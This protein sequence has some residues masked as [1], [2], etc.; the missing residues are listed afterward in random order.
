MDP[1]YVITLENVQPAFEQAIAL[2][3]I[4]QAEATHALDVLQLGQNAEQNAA[5]ALT[6][7][8]EEQYYEFINSLERNPNSY[9][10]YVGSKL[11]ASTIHRIVEILETHKEYYEWINGDRMQCQMVIADTD[12]GRAYSDEGELQRACFGFQLSLSIADFILGI[13]SRVLDLEKNPDDGIVHEDTFEPTLTAW[14]HWLGTHPVTNNESELPNQAAIFLELSRLVENIP[15][16]NV[17]LN[18]S[19]LVARLLR[20]NDLKHNCIEELKK[21]KVLSKEAQRKGGIKSSPL[22]KHPGLKTKIL[23]SYDDLRNYNIQKVAAEKALKKHS[24]EMK[25]ANIKWSPD[26]VIRHAKKRK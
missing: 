15:K 16:I 10:D 11:P 17:S 25:D 8:T 2:G 14:K 21:K 20:D 22:H 3:T 24:K 19:A 23:D 13:A 26:S 1:E 9:Y 5:E 12:D 4:N 6:Q 18:N 7:I